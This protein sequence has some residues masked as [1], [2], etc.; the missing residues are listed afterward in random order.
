MAVQPQYF[1]RHQRY[2]TYNYYE[3]HCNETKRCNTGYQIVVCFL[4]DY[5]MIS[6]EHNSKENGTG[7]WDTLEVGEPILAEEF[8]AV[9][10]IAL[11]NKNVMLY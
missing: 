5:P 10:D 8:K 7:T 11:E 6:V 2:G 9:Y 1:K 4:N 3:V